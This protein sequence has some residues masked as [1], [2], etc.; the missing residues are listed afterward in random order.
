MD[1]DGGLI[2]VL[3]SDFWEESYQD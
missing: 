2:F 1:M 3:I